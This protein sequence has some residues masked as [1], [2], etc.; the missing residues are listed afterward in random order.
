MKPLNSAERTNAFLRFLL[1]F[2]IT[3]A[4]IVTVIFFSVEVPRK[5]NEQLRKKM[6]TFQTEKESSEAF[7]KDMQ[8]TQVAMKNYMNKDELTVAT[9][10]RVQNWIEKLRNRVRQMP[11]G[12]N[13]IYELI[14]ENLSELNDAKKKLKDAKL[15][16]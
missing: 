3:V 10:V 4:L 13:S 15:D 9:Q 7:V 14:V 11:N 8:G 5:E 12:E 6:L 2:L 1:L 16:Q